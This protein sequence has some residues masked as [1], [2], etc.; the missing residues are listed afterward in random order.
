MP[1]DWVACVRQGRLGWPQLW[2][3]ISEP[4]D[5]SSLHSTY[6][7]QT[8]LQLKQLKP[9]QAALCCI[10]RGSAQASVTGRASY[11]SQPVSTCDRSFSDGT[12]FRLGLS[13]V[14]ASFGT[15]CTQKIGDAHCFSFRGRVKPSERATCFIPRPHNARIIIQ[16]FSFIHICLMSIIILSYGH[17]CRGNVGLGHGL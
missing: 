1:C 7:K 16:F 17:V 12:Y 8:R 2:L 10:R 3:A 4:C 5:E 13:P 9:K 14:A 6:K 11:L 15:N